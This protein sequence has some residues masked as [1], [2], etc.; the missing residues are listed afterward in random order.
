MDKL[1]I[2]QKD[3]KYLSAQ[4]ASLIE[5]PKELVRQDHIVNWLTNT[6]TYLTKWHKRLK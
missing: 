4:R 5:T 1:E 3:G 6:V 2:Q